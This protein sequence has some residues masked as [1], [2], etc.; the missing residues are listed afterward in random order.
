VFRRASIEAG[1]ETLRVRLAELLQHPVSG[2]ALPNGVPK[3]LHQGSGRKT[4]SLERF[5]RFAVH[6]ANPA[7]EWGPRRRA[8]ARR[9]GARARPAWEQRPIDGDDS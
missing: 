3:Q 8:Q 5:P 2:E 9:C 7:H 6:F 1:G 4:R